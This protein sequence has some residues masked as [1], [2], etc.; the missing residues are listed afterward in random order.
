MVL[1]VRTHLSSFFLAHLGDCV[2]DHGRV[3]RRLF[4]SESPLR[5]LESILD[6]VVHRLIAEHS[7]VLVVF[8]VFVAVADVI[9]TFSASIQRTPNPATHPS[10]WEKNLSVDGHPTQRQSQLPKLEDQCTCVWNFQSIWSHRG[11]GQ[12]TQFCSILFF[13]YHILR[14]IIFVTLYFVFFY[15]FRCNLIPVC[16]ISVTSY[17]LCI[18]DIM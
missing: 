18:A 7:I 9:N 12:N 14:S 11:K 17:I 5:T 16:K 6:Q 1:A 3:A 13:C 10:Q 4:L 2:V 15:L 8:V